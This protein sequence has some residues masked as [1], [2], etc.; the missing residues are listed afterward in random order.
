MSESTAVNR[1][2]RIGVVGDSRSDRIRETHRTR[3]LFATDMKLNRIGRDPRNSAQTQVTLQPARI[4]Q[5]V[6]HQFLRRLHETACIVPLS[7]ANRSTTSR[8]SLLSSRHVIGLSARERRSLCRKG[9]DSGSGITPKVQL[10]QLPKWTACSTGTRATGTGSRRSILR[11][12]EFRNTENPKKNGVFN[13]FFGRS[14]S[15]HA[16]CE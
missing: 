12:G 5:Q 10:H 8:A 13:S 11:L 15:R 7:S 16:S 6:S 14:S 3:S 2:E 9:P 1:R 4:E